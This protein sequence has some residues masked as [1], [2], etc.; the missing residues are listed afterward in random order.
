METKIIDGKQCAQNERARIKAETENLIAR[1]VQPGLAVIIVG[2]DSA[3]KVYVRNKIKVSSIALILFSTASLLTIFVGIR[4]IHSENAKII[5][6]A[7]VG[8]FYNVLRLVTFLPIYGAKCLD[9]KLTTFY[10]IILMNVLSPCLLSALTVATN[11][12]V[13]VDS[14]L[15]FIAVCAAT[16]LVGIVVNFFVLFRRSERTALKAQVIAVV[17]KKLQK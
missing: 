3:S 7:S 10:P 17:R 1:G 13:R 4:F 15:L 11:A 16:G 6:I 8:A 5:Y 14:W 2:E 12:F 9:F